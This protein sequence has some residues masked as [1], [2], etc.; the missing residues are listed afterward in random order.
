[1]ASTEEASS[2]Q[3][4]TPPDDQRCRALTEDGER[5]TRRATDG[6][7]CY[8][9]DEDDQTV[10]EENGSAESAES[11]SESESPDAADSTDT[12]DSTD[13]DDSTDDD[14]TA[15]DTG[16]TASS[17]MA[18]RGAVVEVAG[19]LIGRPLDGV[20][21]VGRTDDGWRAVVEVVERRAV[22]DTQ[23]ILGRY[24]LTLDSPD[25]VTSY[26]RTG[27]YRRAD[28]GSDEY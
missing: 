5:C 24:E 1:M 12:A 6:A 25:D 4:G 28:T 20:V 19:D 27:R 8:Q 15:S 21:E 13:A 11:S 23:D 16:E 17:V 9:H 26:R 7:F 22:P 14:E 3:D 18:V 2:G 10:D